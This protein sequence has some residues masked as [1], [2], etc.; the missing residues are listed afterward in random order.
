[1]QGAPMPITA[2]IEPP[3]SPPHSYYVLVVI[4][5]I[6]CSVLNPT[7]VGLGLPAVILSGLVSLL[8]I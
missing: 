3:H 6:I 7:S 5:M 8:Y 2:Y 1:M 4:T